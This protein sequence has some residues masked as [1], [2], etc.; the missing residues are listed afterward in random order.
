MRRKSLGNLVG[1][2]VGQVLSEVEQGRELRAKRKE[3]E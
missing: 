1:W 2:R 3:R